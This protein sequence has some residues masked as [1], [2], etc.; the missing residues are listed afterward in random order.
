VVPLAGD[1]FAQ[2]VDSGRAGQ[3]PLAGSTLPEGKADVSAP[4]A[5]VGRWRAPVLVLACAGA[6]A[7]ATAI[8]FVVMH[9]RGGSGA[10]AA[11]D[12]P[13]MRSVAT[14]L[15]A[16]SDV[17]LDG[18][19][20]VVGEKATLH[21]RYVKFTLDGHPFEAIEQNPEKPS[22]WGKLA[23]A[24]HRVVEFKDAAANRYI[25]VT[26]DGERVGGVPEAP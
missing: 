2:T 17:E 8:A 3:S 13:T 11:L 5:K 9:G 6:A 22:A 19:H 20:Y 10:H 24:G 7:V 4:V 14:Q 23:R 21:L 12:T 1:A 18:R 16:G 15:F 26:V 25:G